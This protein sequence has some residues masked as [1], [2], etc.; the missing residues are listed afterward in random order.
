MRPLIGVV[1]FVERGDVVFGRR[2]APYESSYNLFRSRFGTAN[3]ALLDREGHVILLEKW[4]IRK[5][6]DEEIR[7]YNI[8]K[9]VPPP[10]S[11]Q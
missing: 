2:D 10:L 3:N 5:A 6:S 9:P 1:H 11:R 8:V 4:I 7:E